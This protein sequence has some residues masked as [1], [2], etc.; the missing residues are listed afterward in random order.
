M[1]A[2]LALYRIATT[3]LE[4]F[5][6]ALVSRRVKSGKERAARTGERFGRTAISRPDG[7]LLWMHGASVG[8]SKLLLDLFE[9]LRAK[10]PDAS[11]VVTTQTTTSADMIEAKSAPGVIHQMAPVDG[12]IAV[13][14]FLSH[15]RPNAAVFAEGEIWPN[16]LLGLKRSGIPAVLAN[17][18]MTTKSLTTWNSRKSSARELFAAFGFIG[19]ADQQTA[20]GLGVA[21]SRSIG[22]VGNLKM[23]T[24]ITPPPADKVATLRAALGRP[25]LLAAS[26]HPGED[27]FALKAFRDVRETHPSALLIIVPRHP[28]RGGAIA[29]EVRARNFACQQWSIDRTTPT[30]ATD[31]LVADTIGELLF[32]F[33]LT[34]AVYLGGATAEGIGGH[35]AI[36]PAQ[37]GKRVFTGPHS[38]N[39]K[40]TFDVLRQASA[41]VV[42]SAP[43]ELAAYWRDELEGGLPPFDAGDLF[44]GFQAPFDIT[45]GAIVAM[46]PPARAGA[47][48]DA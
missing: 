20:D 40:D 12:P 17:A 3:M 6:P 43:D 18:R 31:V 8:E 15:W 11:A 16:M 19:A 28:D 44:A 26:T 30:A 24:K 45:V 22:L 27:T 42:G 9:A 41:L 47:A 32:W 7:P 1:T 39:F 29:A 2:S 48:R 34:D 21:I 10:R 14:R 36:E 5:A 37:L 4:P 23:A 35:N 25:I 46:L 38:F 13:K 33:A